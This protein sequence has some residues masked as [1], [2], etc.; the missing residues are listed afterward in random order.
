VSRIDSGHY[1]LLKGDICRPV[2]TTVN[3][4][5]KRHQDHFGIKKWVPHDIRRTVATQL[6]ELGVLPH[7]VEK[8]LNHKMQGVMAV[9]NKA[10]YWPERVE[11]LLQWQEKIKRIVAGKRIISIKREA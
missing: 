5:V 11:A 7:V 9:Y 8:I 1:S 4:A 6:N 2:Y 3:R 10:E